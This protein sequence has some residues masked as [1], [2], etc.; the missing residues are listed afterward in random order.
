MSAPPNILVVGAGAVGQAYG[1]HLVQG[2]VR[3]TYFVRERYAEAL[4]KGVNVRCHNGRHKGHHHFTEFRTLTEPKQLSDETWDQVWLCISSPALRGAWLPELIAQIGDAT[5]VMLQ[6]GVEDHAYVTGLIAP[7]RVVHGMITLTSYQAP[8]KGHD[9][10]E[11]MSWWFPPL[12]PAP[13][14]GR[15]EAT[16]AIARTLKLN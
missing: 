13:F 1:F 14:M 10:P 11:A 4:S 9:E 2:G 12:S 16:R 6:P 15:R 5:L 7:E 3:L 8:L